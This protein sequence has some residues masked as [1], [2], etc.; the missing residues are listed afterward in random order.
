MAREGVTKIV[1]LNS[2]EGKIRAPIG[3]SGWVPSV[4]YIGQGRPKRGI[5]VGL[6][7]CLRVGRSQQDGSR[8]ASQ[9][10]EFRAKRG[11]KECHQK[12][13]ADPPPDTTPRLADELTLQHCVPDLGGNF[14]SGWSL[15]W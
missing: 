6:M 4:R 10:S 9:R 11:R 15:V 2:G 13:R 3:E 5:P 12:R 1:V 14:R 7:Y 8:V